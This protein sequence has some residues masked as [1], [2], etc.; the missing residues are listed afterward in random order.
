[1]SDYLDD[2]SKGK[3]HTKLFSLFE[4]KFYTNF[5]QQDVVFLG[6]QIRSAEQIVMQIG[7]SDLSSQ[8]LTAKPAIRCTLD[9][10][11]ATGF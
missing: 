5:D 1:M 7:G 10:K 9:R 8:S 4:Y 2:L 3:N 11:Q 6:A